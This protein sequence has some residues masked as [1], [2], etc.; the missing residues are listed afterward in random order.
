MNYFQLIN[1]GNKRRTR[2]KQT[3]SESTTDTQKITINCR[4]VNTGN[5]ETQWKESIVELA[6]MGLAEKE[7][8]LKI[9]STLTCPVIIA[10]KISHSGLASINANA[11]HE[12]KLAL[13][14]FKA[15][16]AMDKS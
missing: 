15:H 12:L 10:M 9:C 3:P 14:Y 6:T 1:Y 13:E 16:E 7:I 4:M 5:L 8:A 11:Q 2:K